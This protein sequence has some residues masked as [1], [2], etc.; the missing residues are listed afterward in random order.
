MN[1]SVIQNPPEAI[2][3]SFLDTYPA[4]TFL[5][6]LA[7]DRFNQAEGHQT[8]RL[9]VAD[10]SEWH[11]IALVILIKAKRGTYLLCAHGPIIRPETDS[12]SVL[13]TLAAEFTRLG[14]E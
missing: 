10:G 13:Q 9:A 5:Q 2:W 7:W 4:P 14:R 1:L 11:A 12:A 3:E 8:I 6:R